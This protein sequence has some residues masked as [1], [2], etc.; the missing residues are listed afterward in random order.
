MSLDANEKTV[1]VEGGAHGYGLDD[2]V[3]RLTPEEIAEVTGDS[4]RSPSEAIDAAE[5][6]AWLP[7]QFVTPEALADSYKHA[8]NKIR[9]QG[10]ELNR[11]REVATAYEQ[12]AQ[13]E[14]LLAAE[15]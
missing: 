3:H 2:D 1:P 10:E 5:R 13:N 8:V 6:P 14:A 9:E 12:T 11:L 15:M 4:P 7:S